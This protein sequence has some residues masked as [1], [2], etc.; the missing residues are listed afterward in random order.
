MLLRCLLFVAI[1]GVVIGL[2]DERR[3][4]QMFAFVVCGT[5]WMVGLFAR[6]LF[7]V[8]RWVDFM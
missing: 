1:F 4:W 8:V 3:C 5:S 6:G 7:V 2:L